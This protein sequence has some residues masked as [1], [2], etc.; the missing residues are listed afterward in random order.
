VR[1]RVAVSRWVGVRCEIHVLNGVRID[2]PADADEGPGGD[3][4]VQG[5]HAGCKSRGYGRG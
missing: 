1:I 4:K 3:P 2:G 5:E